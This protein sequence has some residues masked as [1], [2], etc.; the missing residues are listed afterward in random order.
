VKSL[1]DPMFGGSV[2]E[3]AS[4]LTY[5]VEYNGERTRDFKVGVFEYPRLERADADVA[6]P[7]YTGQAAKHIKDTRRLS[8]VEGSQLGLKL[9]LNKPVVSARLVPKGHEEGAVPLNI[10][11][12]RAL[13]ELIRRAIASVQS[14]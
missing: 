7:E 3:V 9:Q 2:T 5:H 4:N 13:A 8:A 14:S 11:T 6:F 1:A 12:N 10:E